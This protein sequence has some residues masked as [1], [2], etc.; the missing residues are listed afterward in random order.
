[1]PITKP[2]PAAPNAKLRAEINKSLEAALAE[3]DRDGYVTLEEA[4]R[5]ADALL[6]ELDA[7]R[8]KS[9]R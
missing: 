2:Q 3:A 4:E 8:A 7:T 6:K 5:K 9:T 1:M